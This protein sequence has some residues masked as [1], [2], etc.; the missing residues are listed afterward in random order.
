MLVACAVRVAHAEPATASPPA[1]PGAKSTWPE[2]PAKLSLQPEEPVARLGIP[3]LHAFGLMTTLRVT[4][5]YLWPDPFAETS[6]KVIAA[7]YREA[8][9]KPPKW[10]SR[11]SAFE[12]DG[13]PWYINALGHQLLGSELYLRARSCHNGPLWAFGFAALAS[14][15]WEYAIEASGVRPSALDLWYTPVSGMILGEGRYW[16]HRLA[17]QIETRALRI[18]LQALLDPL[19][20]LE[21]AVGSSC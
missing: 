19:G 11:R 3:A 8:F 20:D 10:D 4:E 13:D 6:P 16:G 1:D 15:T 2:T 5:A 17:G 21:R 18:V 9:T 7:H 14:A 12:W